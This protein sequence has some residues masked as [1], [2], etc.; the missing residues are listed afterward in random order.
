MDFLSSEI[1]EYVENHTSPESDLL[2][3]LNRET[4]ANVMMPRM[5]SGHLQ[6]RVLS[7]F[8]HMLRPK[9]ILEV[10]TYT[11]YSALCMA[12]GLAE[13]GVLTTI[14]VNE[15]LE[16]MVRGYFDESPYAEKIKY[17]IGNAMDVIPSLDISPELV[18]IDADKKSNGVY[19]DMIIDHV[20]A[21]GIIMVDN[22]LWSG[23]T[24]EGKVDKKT[25]LILDFNSKIHNDDRVENVLFPVR[26]GLIVMRKK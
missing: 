20:P 10:G 12:E 22:V 25:Q 21:G 6:G 18:F 5:L 8:S 1:Q 4:H 7:L 24:V 19:Y 9:N 2:K 11:G 16:D 23:K 17:I 3:K 14:D 26:D 15:E 13:D